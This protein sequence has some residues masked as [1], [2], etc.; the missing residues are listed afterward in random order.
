[1]RPSS[2]Y[3][4][5]IEFGDPGVFVS[6]EERPDD[7]ATN[8]ASL[9]FELPTLIADKKLVV[10]Y[11]R[12][13]RNEIEE[14]GDYDLEG[15]FVRLGYAIDSIKAKRVV[16][17]TVESLFSGLSNHSILRAELRR[18][19]FWLKDKGVTAIITGEKGDASLTKQG[20]EE[21]VSDCVIQLDHRVTEQVYTRRLR[22]VKFRG[23]THG[24]NEYPF[25]IDEDGF[26]VVP[27]TSLGLDHK[28][29]NHRVSTGVH[30]LDNML[31]GGGYYQGSSVLIT[32]TAGT[33][34]SSLAAAFANA[35]C[36]RGERALYFAFEESQ[37][38]INRNMRSIGMNL[39]PWIDKG[40]L[41]FH[42]ARPTLYGL[43][44][45]LAKIYKLIREFQPQV[46]IVDPITSLLMAG[47][48]AEIQAMLMRLV[49]FLKERGITALFTSLTLGGH[50]L[51]A[52]DFG[53][54]SLVDTW[55]NLRDMENGSERNRAIHIIKS[56]GMA[57]SNQVRE[58]LLSSNGVDIVDVYTGSG[59]VLAGSARLAQQARE[60]AD[61]LKNAQDIERR[62][63]TLEHKRLAM[64]AR[65]S[66][67]RAKF[68]VDATEF[69]HETTDENRRHLNVARDREKML[70]SPQGRPDGPAGH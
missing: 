18:M 30:R 21:Y 32:G 47:G 56:R 64:E 50:V 20:L 44:M 19:F 37:A 67:I 51:E 43:E 35:A 33:G 60:E 42:V 14:T 63:R 62:Q 38:Q 15:L 48:R 57:H 53:V 49:D 61:A 23:S 45:H 54:S 36:S 68:E 52:T 40:L 22:V 12:V 69:R 46:A 16:L 17:D 59:K 8:V 28:A 29:P 4:V 9:G 58:F 24:T 5:A 1:M 7:L 65:I 6:F 34:K 13:E 26:S 31:I 25:L 11:V 10:E 3:A 27:I 2:S 66:A 55:I 70:V 39:A 41:Q